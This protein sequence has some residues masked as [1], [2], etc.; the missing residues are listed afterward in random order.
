MLKRDKNLKNDIIDI[1][2]NQGYATYARLLQLFDVYTTDDPKHIAYMIP[3]KAAIVLNENVLYEKQV[4][5]LVRHEI[6]HEFLTH[7]ERQI[8]FEKNHPGLKPPK[9]NNQLANIAADFEISNLG[10]TDDDKYR[11]RNIQVGDNDYLSGLVTEL[12]EPGWENL[13]F[14]EMY[15]KLLEKTEQEQKQIAQQLQNMSDIDADDL[16]KLSDE[17][18]QTVDQLEG[19]EGQEDQ[20]EKDQDSDKSQDSKDQNSDKSQSSKNQNSENEE[21]EDQK[22]ESNQG[23]D[24]DKTFKNKKQDIDKLNKM[25]DQ[26]DQ[27]KDQVDKIDNDEKKVERT[28][29][30]K[31]KKDIEARAKEISKI[32]KDIRVKDDLVNETRVKKIKQKAARAA[33]KAETYATSGLR[34]FTLNLNRFIK[35]AIDAG[36]DYSYAKTNPSYSRYGFLMPTLNPMEGP[37]P[38]INVYHDVSFSFSDERKTTAAMQAIATLN[39]YVRKGEIIINVY[40]FSD[41][42]YSSRAAGLDK[43]TNGKPILDHIEATKPQNVIVITDGDITDCDHVVTVPGAVW[44]LFY[45]GRSQNLID[46]LKGKKENRYYD[47]NWSNK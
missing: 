35:N 41:E 10:Y 18:D 31:L 2:R 39:K 36:E 32:L 5:V 20:E 26:V 17:I 45:G 1:L 8:E 13:T 23:S 25:K 7:M 40:Y 30:S 38:S 12:E 9:S 43:G 3:G 28:S 14:E 37:V 42:V 34:Q 6:L 29:E 4:S 22:P 15:E 46:H 27:M 47:I 21:E 19:Q 16:Q 44:M 33:K 24:Q 11:V